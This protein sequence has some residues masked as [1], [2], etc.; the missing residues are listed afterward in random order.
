MDGSTLHLDFAANLSRACQAINWDYAE[1]WISN[2]ETKLLELSPVWYGH[3][4]R[5]S[6][7]LDDLR[8]FQA[9]SEKIVLSMDE[10]LPGRIWRSQ[11]PQWIDDVSVQSESYFLR[12]QIA[13]AFNLKAGFG[14]PIFCDRC[15]IA[16]VIFFT[17][18][19]C[20]EDPS[21]V[22]CAIA[23]TSPLEHLNL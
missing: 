6:A 21:L 4:S 12:N 19:A 2:P 14:F 23:A 17:D 18:R 15:S 1:V 22:Q 8:K 16:I 20:E 11:Q 3:Q 13:K 10:G 7:R 5:N 9:C